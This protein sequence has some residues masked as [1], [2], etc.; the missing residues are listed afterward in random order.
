MQGKFSTPVRWRDTIVGLDN[1]ILAAIEVDSGKLLWKSGRYGHGQVLRVSDHLL[2]L[3]EKGE[4]VFLK[5]KPGKNRPG[6]LE[7]QVVLSGKTWNHVAFAAPY[8]L[9][10]NSREAACFQ[11]P[12]ADEVTDSHV[13]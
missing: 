7:R 8:L 3:S 4:L 5:L 10:R 6:V 1:G 9:L 13:P 11:L 2:L 12:L